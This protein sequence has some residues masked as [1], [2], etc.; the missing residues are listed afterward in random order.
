M[1]FPAAFNPE[2]FRGRGRPVP[3][4]PLQSITWDGAVVAPRSGFERLGWHGQ[5]ATRRRERGPARN[6]L[7]VGAGPTGRRLAAILEREHI[8]RRAVVG[9]LDEGEVLGGRC[10]RPG[11]KSCPDRAPRIRGRSHPGDS[12]SA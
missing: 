7:I 4:K 10:P 2:G 8:D 6:V 11:E 9:F 12:R 1:S 5:A 3:P